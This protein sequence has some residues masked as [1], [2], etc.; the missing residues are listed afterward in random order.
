MASNEGDTTGIPEGYVVIIGPDEERYV[1]PQFMVPALH[2]MFDGYRKKADL[3]VFKCPGSVSH[4]SKRDGSVSA[5]VGINHSPADAFDRH[6]RW[7]GICHI[8]AFVPAFA[9]YQDCNQCL[10]FFPFRYMSSTVPHLV[11]LERVKSWLQ[12]FP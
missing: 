3:E 10:N 9:G 7:P 8:P 6:M 2:Q 12:L 11:S 4:L 5:H 1:V